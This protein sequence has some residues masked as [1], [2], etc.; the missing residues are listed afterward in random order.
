MKKFI[1]LIVLLFS[2]A[3]L[4][5]SGAP[6]EI[7]SM[8]TVFKA[9]HEKVEKHGAQNVLLVFDIDNT[10]LKTKQDFSSYAWGTW[11]SSLVKAKSPD[12]VTNELQELYN[13]QMVLFTLGQMEPTEKMIPKEIAALQNKGVSILALTSRG[14][15]MRSATEKSF[16]RNGYNFLQNVLFPGFPGSYKPKYGAG[17]RVSFQNG[18]YL[19][20]G[21]NKGLMLKDLLERVRRKFSSI[22]FVDDHFKHPGNV[23]E[24]FGDSGVDLLTYRY[25]YMDKQMK[26]FLESDKKDSIEKWKKLRAAWLEA[27]PSAS[28]SIR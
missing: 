11:Q 7:L 24:V 8:T 17:R 18:I 5:S 20:E 23:Y 14:V 26:R 25:G 4:A 13:L 21:Q 19:T 28:N 3:S 6:Q 10:L 2:S 16:E 1:Y 27:F 12:A 9:A 15:H 22:I